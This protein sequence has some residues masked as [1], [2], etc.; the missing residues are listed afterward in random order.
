MN[1]DFLAEALSSRQLLAL[2][3]VCECG[4]KKIP[5]RI[6]SAQW[7]EFRSIFAE[8]FKSLNETLR[9]EVLEAHLMSVEDIDVYDDSNL[10]KLLGDHR[11]ALAVLNRDLEKDVR[12]A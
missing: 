10:T 7:E 4:R 3:Y 1:R 11:D 2:L 5:P 9:F 8:R 6:P 12:F